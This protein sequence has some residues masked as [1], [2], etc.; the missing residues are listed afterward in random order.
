[1]QSKI[2]EELQKYSNI[3]ILGFGKEGRSTY[4]YIRK[5][6]TSL[7]LTILDAKDI[8]LDE[9]VEFLENTDNLGFNSSSRESVKKQNKITYISINRNIDNYLVD[10]KAE[11]CVVF[12]DFDPISEVINLSNKAQVYWFCFESSFDRYDLK[13]FQGF[14]YKVKN[15]VDLAQGLVKV[16]SKR[17]ES[18][19]FTDNPSVIN[20]GKARSRND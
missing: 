6:D 2:I 12:A 1:M 7:K 10:K 18:L 15:V 17:F 5:Y 9:L 4:N 8:T 19:C 16:N 13:Y 3:A 11:K 20:R 14:I